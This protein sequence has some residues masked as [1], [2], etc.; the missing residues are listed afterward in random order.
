[1]NVIILVVMMF[2]YNSDGTYGDSSR[3]E[4]VQ[5]SMIE[6][7]ASLDATMQE[8]YDHQRP[9]EVGIMAMCRPRKVTSDD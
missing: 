5:N 3:H 2:T 6:C 1:M 7:Q 4:Y 8:Y 9:D